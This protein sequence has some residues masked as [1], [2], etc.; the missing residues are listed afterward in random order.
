MTPP[1]GASARTA[2]WA[3]PA[4]LLTALR[5]VLVPVVAALLVEGGSTARWWAFAVF[6]FAAASD[7]VD[8]WLARRWVGTSRWG[9]LADPLADK[10][11]VSG[12]LAVLAARGEVSW[13]VVVVIIA[14]EVAVTLQ[15]QVLL[16][17][18]VVMPAS[19]WGK[20][21]TVT[22]IVAVCCYLAPVVPRG[23]AAATLTVAV[24]ATVGSGLEYVV[25]GRRL[26]R[27]R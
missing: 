27:A 20:A 3:N 24:V 2:T 4:N 17:R 5:V 15:R 7:G 22:Q 14:R 25:R 21:K 19:G 8:G 6:T 23:L 13:W 18:G 26:T 10:L 12:T 1:G 9:A 16:R 11:L